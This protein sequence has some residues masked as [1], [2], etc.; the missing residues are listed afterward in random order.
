MALRFLWQAWTPPTDPQTSFKNKTVIVTGANTGLGYA[1]A[2]K[3]AALHAEL[4][5]LGVRDVAKGEKAQQSINSL[6]G[7][8]SR[9]EVWPLDM[10]SYDSIQAFAARAVRL[11][12]LNVVVLNAGVYMVRY[13]K[14]PYGWEET[15]QVNVLSTALLGLLLLP[16]LKAS[17]G[18]SDGLPVL[19]IVASENYERAHVSAARDQLLA[20]Y[21]AAM[22]YNS[23]NQYYVSKLFVMYVM[24]TLASLAEASHATN[25][26]P[27]VLVTAVCPGGCK[28][29]LSRGYNGYMAIAFKAVFGALFLRTAEQGARSLVSGVLLGEEA[30]GRLW[31]HDRLRPLAPLVSGEQGELLRRKVWSEIVEALKDVPAV[32]DTIAGLE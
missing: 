31:Q 15:L 27:E 23:S 21:N 22:G 30:H 4:V 1:A 2:A 5:I 18:A 7:G 25:R 10:N 8:K 14:S 13:E 9:L 11:E 17:S 6:T 28:S 3:F 24:Q 16:V 19:E 32:M 12:Q 29:E 20:N 26:K